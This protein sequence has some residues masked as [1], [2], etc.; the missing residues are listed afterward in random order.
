VVTVGAWAPQPI[1]I[2]TRFAKDVQPDQ[3]P[4]YPRPQLTRP[5]ETWQH[6][7]GLWQIDYSV[8]DLSAPP[9][10]QT[11]A[12]EILVPYPLES[13]LSGI[14]KRAPDSSMFYRRSFPAASLLPSCTGRRLLHVE[15]SDYQTE[16]YVNTKHLGTHWG[17]FAPFSYDITDQVASA[18]GE[19]EIIFGVYDGKCYS[20]PSIGV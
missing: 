2:S 4:E 5:A 12:E 11:L 20:R 15:K 18:D 9:F 10:G 1:S 8:K 17:G 7:N 19:T 6:L 3:T 16:T 14:R 13:S